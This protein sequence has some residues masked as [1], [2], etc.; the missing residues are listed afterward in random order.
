MNQLC[1]IGVV[2]KKIRNMKGISQE[3]LAKD[4]CSVKQIYR[5]ESGK[6]IPTC[7]LLNQLSFKLG[8]DLSKYLIRSHCADP[9]YTV[10][11]FEQL[12][13]CYRHSRFEEMTQIINGIPS[14]R[15]SNFKFN[16]TYQ[17]LKW[18]ELVAQEKLNA[19]IIKIND[20]QMLLKLS[21]DKAVEDLYKGVMTFNELRIV[22]AM[23][24]S[25]QSPLDM[26][27]S[28]KCL[29]QLKG[30]MV[31]K[32]I[33]IDKIILEKIYLDLS[34]LFYARG[35]TK[36]TIEFL[37]EDVLYCSGNNIEKKVID[38]NDLM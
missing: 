14:E 8:E 19:K 28:A 5:V 31:D 24:T 13:E 32:F 38:F 34:V 12:E 3:E 29:L 35:N 17:L 16:D 1:N 11:T 7:N 23:I 22:Y 21:T 36:C 26:H 27:Q 15:C 25:F 20:Y 9:I 10:Q 6:N 4:I 18:Y 33:N 37:N 2:V 30:Y